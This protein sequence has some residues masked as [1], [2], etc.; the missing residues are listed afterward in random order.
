MKTRWRDGVQK[1]VGD[2][3]NKEKQR[4]KRQNQLCTL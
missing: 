3:R 2:E 4:E 1:E